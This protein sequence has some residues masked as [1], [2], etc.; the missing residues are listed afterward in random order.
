MRHEIQS[1]LRFNYQPAVDENENLY[2]FGP[3]TYFYERKRL[4]YNFNTNFEIKTRRSQSAHRVFYFDTRLT[5]DFTD[6][7]PLYRRKYEPI[8]SDFTFVPLPSRNLNMTVR[9]TH[10]PNPHPDDG[11]QFKMVGFRT[12]IRYTDRLGTSVSETLLA[13][14]TRQGRHPDLLR[15]LDATGLA[16]T[17][18]LT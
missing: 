6:F 4:T 8:E 18:N 17:L 13:I 5:A 12:N 1:S 9:F 11:K 14:G 10:D 3:S 15:R 2:P 7:E 16:K